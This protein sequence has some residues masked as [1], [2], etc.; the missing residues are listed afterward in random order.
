MELIIAKPP[1]SFGFPIVDH[2]VSAMS[3]LQMVGRV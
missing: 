3:L 2:G 1:G